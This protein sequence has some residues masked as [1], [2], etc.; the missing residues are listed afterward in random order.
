MNFH[1]YVCP[2]DLNEAWCLSQAKG[3]RIIAGGM[4]IRYQKRPFETA[5]DLSGLGLDRI[6]DR[7]SCFRIGAMVTLHALETDE[8]L[9]RLTGGAF[10]TALE[11]IVGVQ[12]RNAATV[13]GSVHGRFGFSDLLPLLLVLGARVIFYRGSA[14]GADAAEG[15]Y[16]VSLEQFLAV[17]TVRGDLLTAVEIPNRKLPAA[18][19]C[20]RTFSTGFPVLVCDSVLGPEGRILTAVGA[21]PHR[22]VLV[23]QQPG[24]TEE[25]YLLRLPESVV[26]GSNRD[27]S[28]AYRKHLAGVF[29][30]RNLT[31][32]KKGAETK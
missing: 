19:Q 29:V 7:G 20:H 28:A 10:R 6:E 24:E 15:E 4:W 17:P 2:A 12:F 9:N 13:G 25:E 22:A 1:R 26:F 16:S 8:P 3:S 31:I 23:A 18:V 11:R 14:E 27:A 5:V 32:L 30:Q 21:R